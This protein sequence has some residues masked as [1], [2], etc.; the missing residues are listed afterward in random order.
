[1]YSCSATQER[2][3]AIL[4]TSF[5][6]EQKKCLFPMDKINILHAEYDQGSFTQE[7][8]DIS[9]MTEM[10]PSHSEAENTS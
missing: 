8:G 2:L 3:A 1:M 4:D 5:Q 6:R 9:R 7:Q 10:D